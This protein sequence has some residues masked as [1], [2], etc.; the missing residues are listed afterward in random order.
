MNHS[1]SH[2]HMF[3]SERLAKSQIARNPPEQ[4]ELKEDFASI[5]LELNGV[6]IGNSTTGERPR[7]I[8]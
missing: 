8:D 1:Q 5:G 2:N 6:H 3:E 4:V 7:A